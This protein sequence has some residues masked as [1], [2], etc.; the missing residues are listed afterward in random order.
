MSRVQR[1]ADG[2]EDFL[3]PGC[4]ARVL[5]RPSSFPCD[6]NRTQRIRGRALSALERY[7]M[8]PV[9]TEVIGVVPGITWLMK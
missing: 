1:I 7:Q 8:R 5:D 3:V 6:A 9:I 2:V 4:S